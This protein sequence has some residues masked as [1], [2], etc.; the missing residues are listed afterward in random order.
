MTKPSKQA[1]A[2]RRRRVD[3]GVRDEA[4]A[5]KRSRPTHNQLMLPLLDEIADK[6]G[7]VKPSEIYDSLAGRMKIDPSM[8]AETEIFADGQ[9]HNLWQRHVRWARQT[10]VLKGYIAN[11]ARGIWELTEQGSGLL[12]RIR[13]GYVVTVFETDQG[14]ALWATAEA[15]AGVIETGSVNLIYCSPPY[16]ISNGRAYGGFSVPAWLDW[17]RGLGERW[18]DLLQPDGSLMVNLGTVYQRG[19]PLESP[20]QERFILQ[21]VDELGYHF[22]GRQFWFSPSKLPS[23]MPWVV[24]RRQRVKSSVEPILWFSKGKFPKADNR[25]VLVPYK[26]RTLKRYIGK[27]G[28]ETERPSGYRFGDASFSKDNGGAIPPNLIVAPGVVS[29][30]AYREKCRAIGLPGHPEA[31]PEALP[32]FGIRLTTEPGD[33]VYDPLAGS[34]T[35]AAAA[36]RLGR[37]WITSDQAL[38]YVQGSAF[39]FEEAEGFAWCGDSVLPGMY[40]DREPS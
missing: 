39:R 22:A 19:A 30:D 33:L 40:N 9:S 36:E 28:D 7:K 23:P 5:R 10:A 32:D 15:A 11:D 12:K 24:V 27:P 13:P 34:G 20:Y 1:L 16:P 4:E 14:R 25:R 3:A 17:M 21:M 2:A 18:L 37:R 35:T 6:G 8:Q 26:P 38:A 29:N 31:Y